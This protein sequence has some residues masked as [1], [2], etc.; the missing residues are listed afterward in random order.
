MWER[1]GPTSSLRRFGEHATNRPVSR[2]V[3][4]CPLSA[5]FQPVAAP[6]TTHRRHVMP[7]HPSSNGLGGVSFQRTANHTRCPAS[8]F[9]TSPPASGGD[10]SAANSD[11]T[12][13]VRIESN[14]RRPAR[15]GKRAWTAAAG[16]REGVR[17][18]WLAAPQGRG[19]GARMGDYATAK[20]EPAWSPRWGDTRLR[21]TI[22]RPIWDCDCD[23]QPSAPAEG[24]SL[25]WLWYRSSRLPR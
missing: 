2:S 17:M 9:V 18:P 4:V 10:H 12:R 25:P 22:E 23:E 11:G 21:G 14:E 7:E 13:C 20:A 24:H 1:G 8:T 16:T 6:T 19:P 15:C 5:P 3:F